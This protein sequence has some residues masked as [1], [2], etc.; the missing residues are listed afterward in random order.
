MK[1]LK[2]LIVLLLFGIGFSCNKK[3]YPKPIEVINTAVYYSKLV[4]DNTP[5]VLEAGVDGY[6]MYSSYEVDSFSLYNYVADLKKI[7]C[8]D[9]T[10]SLKIQINDYKTSSDFPKIDSSL[11][12]ARYPYFN[13]N[14]TVSYSVKFT[15]QSDSTTTYSWDFGDGNFSSEPNPNHVYAKEGEYSVCLKTTANKGYVNTIC[16]KITV[17]KKNFKAMISSSSPS[18]NVVKFNANASG[19]TAPY[20]YFWRLAD[21]STYQ[22]SSI[23]H[24][25][26]YR[27]SSAVTLRVIDAVGD[28]LNMNYN[29]KTFT[30]KSSFP[31][32]YYVS[33][34][35]Q[36]GAVLPFS[37]ITIHWKAADGLVYSSNSALQPNDSFFEILSATEGEKNE[38]GEPTRKINAKFKCRLYNGTKSIVVNDAEVVVCVAYKN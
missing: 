35:Q 17:N 30:D 15:S 34:I 27:G 33:N 28:T 11:H 20:S 9:C 22:Q 31:A 3:E 8:S 18:G 6:Y 5:V 16:N 12:P 1:A 37:K 19:G 23:S 38:K 25:Y 2:F 4:I 26:T 32:N 21:G 24:T 7:D 36:I 14:P 13:E 29:A 10:N